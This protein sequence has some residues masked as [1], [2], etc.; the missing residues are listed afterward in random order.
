MFWICTQTCGEGFQEPRS[1]E[2]ERPQ[3]RVCGEVQSEKRV[4]QQAR[5]LRRPFEIPE[6]IGGGVGRSFGATDAG[7]PESSLLWFGLV[8]MPL[9]WYGGSAMCS[10]RTWTRPAP[11]SPST[12]RASSAPSLTRRSPSTANISP[13]SQPNP[14][15]TLGPGA[16]I[17]PTS[18]TK[19]P[20][21][22]LWLKPSA[23]SSSSTRP[24]S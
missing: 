13:R 11:T 9:R 21:L 6:H 18:R 24:T 23:P 5:G 4:W 19:D 14:D 7:L 8:R 15:L 20:R 1:E 10:F 3:E 17:S 16:T 22:T 12:P 2:P